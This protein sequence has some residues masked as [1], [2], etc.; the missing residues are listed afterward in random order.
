MSGKSL[1]LVV[2]SIPSTRIAYTKYF[3]GQNRSNKMLIIDGYQRLMTVNDYIKGIWSGD[4][5]LLHYQTHQVK[6]TMHRG[7]EKHI[8]NFLNPNNEK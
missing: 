6:L 8:A 5:S 1:K 3:F 2:L 4:D 7:K